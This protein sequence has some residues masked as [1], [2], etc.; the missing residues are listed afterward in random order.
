MNKNSMVDKIKGRGSMEEFVY[1]EI[2]KDLTSY[3]FYNSVVKE[4]NYKVSNGCKIVL[5]FSKTFRVEPLVIPNLLCMGYFLQQKYNSKAIVD[6]PDTSYASGVKNY[7]NQIDFIEYVNKYSL[8]DFLTTP[9]G[10]V[11]GKEID[12]ICGTQYFDPE[13]SDAEIFR[14]IEESILPFADEYLYKFLKMEQRGNKIYYVNEIVEFLTEIIINCKIHAMSFSFTTLHAKYS[15]K[16][17][18]ISVSDMGGG[19]SNTIDNRK[20]NTKEVEAILYGVYKR[21]ESKVYGLYNVIRRVLEFNGKVRIH[22][23]NA[24]IIFTPRILDSFISGRIYQDVTFKK[25]NIK[26]QLPFDGV[27]IEIELPLE[28][29]NKLV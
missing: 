27:H 23:N 24:Q 8:Y 29:R 18:Y 25:Y 13:Y 11:Y 21:R 19:F 1:I 4:V 28:R 22:S 3:E 6:I 9:Y 15:A 5:D 10:G 17:I 2:P 20:E 16:M 7:L 14:G 26:E 12:P